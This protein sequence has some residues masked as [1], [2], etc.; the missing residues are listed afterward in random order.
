[1]PYV[2]KQHG[3]RIHVA[4]FITLCPIL[5]TLYH[6]SQKRQFLEAKFRL[7]CL[8]MAAEGALAL[9]FPKSSSCTPG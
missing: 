1:M 5:I 8:A 6:S 7:E 3:K 2:S 4:A 9:F